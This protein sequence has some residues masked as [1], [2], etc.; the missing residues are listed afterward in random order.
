MEKIR[1]GNFVSAGLNSDINPVDLGEN[2]L[3][4]CSNVRMKSG[5]ITPFGG[6]AD[7][8]SI[9]IVTE[10]HFMK[11]VKGV[12]M[13]KWIIA[14]SNKIASYASAFT[15]ITPDGMITVTDKDSWSITSISGITIVNHPT[16]GPLY[17]DVAH[18]KLTS[19]PWKSDVSWSAAKQKCHV[20]VAHRQFIFAL[21]I[22]DD[23]KDIPDGVRWSAPADVGAVPKNWDPLDNTSTAGIMSLGGSGGRIIGALSLRDSLAVYREYGI[24]MFDYVGGQY[25][26][27]ARRIGTDV[28]LLSK[29]AVADVNGTHFFLTYGDVY[30]NDGNT[31]KS[32]ASDKIIKRLSA[33][34]KHNYNRAFAL[35]NA[36]N[37]EVWFCVPTTGYE[38]ANKAFIF[39][40]EYG[41]WL[42]RDLPNIMIADSGPLTSPDTI[43]DNSNITWDGAVKSWGDNATSPFDIM[44]LGL[45]KESDT[46]YKISAIDL[47]LG[48]NSNPYSSIIERTDLAIGGIGVTNTITRI[49]P[50]VT[51]ASKVRVQVGSQMAP[52]GPVQW[53]PFV[54]FSPSDSRKIDIRS[55]GLL[56][57]YR[58]MATDVTANFILTGLDFEYTEAGA[59]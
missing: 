38:Y 36:A 17:M 23:G 40:Y 35:H 24:T 25:V 26:W 46:A 42:V 13:D 44:T 1:I 10:P 14:G 16:V 30:V 55:T 7:V 43:W 12:D 31:T 20:M 58:I 22:I 8:S 27:R 49:Y 19:L 51:G 52:G 47:P 48:F 39:N 4:H 37:K 32:I 21:G 59:R 45:R 11:F 18:S 41:S 57:A 3:T 28:G 54:D 34:D 29:D 2:F 15:D 5:G 33:I 53:K 6:S 56:H 50:H 9:S